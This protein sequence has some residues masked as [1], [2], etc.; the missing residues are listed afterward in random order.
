M[1]R[2]GIIVVLFLS[3]S[4]KT[5]VP[6]NILP[7]YKMEKL[8]LDMLRADQFFIQKQADSATRDSF[9]RFNLY[10]SVFRLHKTNKETFQKSFIYYENHPD[11][12]K[13]VL[14][15]MYKEA[16]KTPEE[17][18]MQKIDSAK[19]LDLKSRIIQRN[20]RTLPK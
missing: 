3:C 13:I 15:S 18:K 1:I 17:R 7:P 14:D 9:N 16:S 10:H 19:K 2:A 4:Q 5:K 12:L 20:K 6:D 8:F 11:L